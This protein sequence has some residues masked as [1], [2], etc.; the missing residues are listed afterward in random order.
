M[1]E[2]GELDPM[3][4]FFTDESHVYF[5]I[6]PNKQNNHEW[7]LSKPENLT[8][9]PLHTAKITVWC[10]LSSTIVIGPQFFEDP[11]TGSA[12]TVTKE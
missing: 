8:S 5:K 9:V 11:D 1:I 6:S 10:G 2:S 4:I 12:S 3:K 7:S